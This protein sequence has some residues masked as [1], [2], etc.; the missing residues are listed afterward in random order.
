MI[1]GIG[2]VWYFRE[3]E[4]VFSRNDNSIMVL[5]QQHLW[6][7]VRSKAKFKKRGG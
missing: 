4:G 6:L 5:D 3:K 1:L 7:C 2:E